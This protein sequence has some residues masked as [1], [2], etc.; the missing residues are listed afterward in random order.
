MN[1]AI[2]SLASGSSGNCYLVYSKEAAVVVDAG[3]S[4]KQMLERIGIL[5]FSP[6]QIRA[7]MVTHEHSDHIRGLSQL[8]KRTGAF[9]YSSGGTINCL[10][11]ALAA[12]TSPMQPGD[13]LRIEDLEIRAFRVSHDAAEPLAFSFRSGGRQASI[14]TDTGVLTDE[15]R[16][17]MRDADILVLESNHDVNIL[18]MGRYPWFLKQRILGPEGHLSNDAAALGLLELMEGDRQTGLQRKRQVLLA[19]LSK[20]NNFPEMALATVRNVLE[21]KGYLAGRDYLLDTLPRDVMSP[22]YWV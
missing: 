8:A 14:V 22:V 11:Q 19:H 3:I 7:I 16:Q 4:G 13:S 15:I 1:L 10:E 18:R 21:E 2:C 6:Q 12:R 9:I 20:E 17:N 5:G